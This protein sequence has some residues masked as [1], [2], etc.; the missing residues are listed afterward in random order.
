MNFTE[1]FPGKIKNRFSPPSFFLFLKACQQKYSYLR[2]RMSENMKYITVILPLKL[3]WEPYYSAKDE[4]VHV[5]SRVKVMFSGR[6]YTG[7]VS[8]TGST[9]PPG[10]NIKE[11]I[12]AENGLP[13]IFPEEIS[14]WKTVAD[15]Y[16]CTVG[17]VYKAAYPAMKTSQEQSFAKKLQ[18][19]QEKKEKL[20]SEYRAKGEKADNEIEK[21]KTR[22]AEMLAKEAADGKPERK[23]TTELKRKL[24]RLIENRNALSDKINVLAA[25]CSSVMS[26][27][28]DTENGH[29]R[30]TN[31]AGQDAAQDDI[32]LSEAQQKAYCTIKSAFAENRTVLLHGVTGSGKTEIYTKLARET[33]SAGKNVLYLVPEIAISRQLED[34][35]SEGIGHKLL[36]FHSAETT[37]E[38]RK[39]ATAIR[40]SDIDGTTY[41]VLG[42]RSAL[43]LPH[44]RLGLIIVDEEHDRS[45]KQ[46]SPAPRY[47]GRDAAVMLAHIHGSNILLGSATPSL[48]S[49]FNA[50]Y[51]KYV[52]VRLDK[53]YYGSEDADI[54][55]IDTI[56]ERK[57]HGM[58]GSFSIRLIREIGQTLEKGEQVMI[59]RGRR[60]YSPILQC[61]GC[62]QILKCPKCNVSLSLHRNPDTA[63]CHHCGYSAPYDEKCP[64]CGQPLH[65]IGAGTQKIE[66]EAKQL[67]P[68][69]EIARLDSDSAQNQKFETETIRKFSKGETDIL[70]GT[71]MLTKG[72]DFPGLTLVAAIYADSILG[73]QDFRADEKAFQTLEQFKGRCGRR[74]KKGKFLIQT[75][76]PEHPVYKRLCEEQSD[77]LYAGLMEERRMFGFP[78]FSRTINIT[79][80]DT[81]RFRCENMA[82]SL[83]ADLRK[84]LSAHEHNVP[85]KEE[86][87]TGPFA[88]AIDKIDDNHLRTIRLTLPKDK[89]LAANKSKAKT[90]IEAFAKQY[91]YSGHIIIDVDPL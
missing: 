54:E 66:E 71:Q 7:V 36:V 5:G 32:I 10:I 81:D 62:G 27:L 9:P 65:G 28:A 50:K 60:S 35:I 15:Y 52:S 20:L 63:V 45:Y 37:A 23:A 64:T 72:F 46:D 56:A 40:Q 55:I 58:R 6:Q 51:G 57:K 17:E 38:R 29:D 11:I 49:V 43:F 53:R 59:L 91:N 77:S 13:D 69:A 22:L 75:S 84:A 68:H 16:M 18:R 61:T 47:N 30:N 34:R 44:N 26:R 88:P 83:S 42:T 33:L 67:F 82:W 1:H 79:I 73:V 12:A 70:I 21:C 2:T 31:T 90:T 25:E 3:D 89:S 48:E 86:I 8:S 39:T 78:P 76:Q 87:V 41:A 24:A 14:F 74:D 80:R 85:E 4:N 19:E